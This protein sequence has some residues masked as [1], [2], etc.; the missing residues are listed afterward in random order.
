M[1]SKQRKE[2]ILKEI[3]EENKKKNKIKKPAAVK[4]A[5]KPATEKKASES[6]KSAKSSAAGSAK[7]PSGPKP[8]SKKPESVETKPARKV[9]RDSSGKKKERD[10]V[11]KEHKA[12]S[13][14]KKSVG[15]QKK[16]K[17]GAAHMVNRI[18]AMD[19]I[20]RIKFFGAWTLVLL[21][22]ILLLV[23][24][25]AS[26][27][28]TNGGES[29]KK[30]D[31]I[32]AADTTEEVSAD[33][34]ADANPLTETTDPQYVDLIT[35][36]ITAMR[37]CD[38]DTMKSLDVNQA[39]YASDVYFKNTASIV[40][41]YQNIKVY[42]KNGPYTN[43][44]TAFVTVDV[45]FR[46]IDHTAA[47]LLQYMIVPMNDGTYKLDTT[48]EDDITDETIANEYMRIGQSEDVLMLID[49]VNQQ[50]NQEIASDANLQ[51]FYNQLQGNAAQSAAP[52]ADD[53]AA[54]DTTAAPAADT[55]A[56]AAETE[57]APA[58]TTAAP[59]Q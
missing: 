37:D 44:Y 23:V 36:Y 18:K 30:P 35:R 39:P 51:N 42:L 14:H 46:N 5:K 20:S 38:I 45:K 6:V 4:P 48:A 58:E 11:K 17:S 32:T 56:A 43:G 59:A 27:N 2:K 3:N 16:K 33:A 50:L 1:D 34:S 8:A 55:T 40:E 13:E 12:Y 15:G 21:I 10:I 22:V 49:S 41:D 25:I 29:K 24:I 26:P 53:P 31:D 9:S 52:A 54:A 57:A 19:R 47:G 7:K 28:R